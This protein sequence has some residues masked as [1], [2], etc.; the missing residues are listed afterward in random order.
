MPHRHTIGIT[1][2]ELLQ[3]GYSGLLGLGLSSVRP[4]RRSQPSLVS[5]ARSRSRSSSC[6]SP[7]PRATSRRWTPSPT[8]RREIRGEYKPIP[9]KTPGLLAM[10]TLAEARGAV[11]QVRHRPLAVA[12]REQPPRRHAPRPDRAQAAG[13]V[14]R[15]DRLAA[16]TS[17]TTPPASATSASRPKARP[18]AS[19]CRRTS[20]KARCSGPGSTRASWG[21]STTSCRSR[22]TPTARLQGRQ[23]PPRRRDGRR[24]DEGPHGAARTRSTTSRSGSRRAPR[25]RSS[26]TSSSRRSRC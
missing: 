14:L 4:Q 20:W 26:P 5:R 8:R 15:Q 12:P 10:R 25:R 16:T 24:P 23:P 7:A 6:S 18:S 3:V 1:R 13:R 11:G 22:T 2:R 17:P 9:T 19:T 21:R